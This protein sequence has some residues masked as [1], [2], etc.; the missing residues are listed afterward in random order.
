MFNEPKI[1]FNLTRKWLKESLQLAQVLR[2]DGKI[3]NKLWHE[4]KFV[5]I[6]QRDFPHFGRADYDK[7]EI[8]LSNEC[9]LLE[10]IPVIFAQFTKWGLPEDHLVLLRRFLSRLPQRMIFDIFCQS[11]VD[12]N[13]GH[14][15]HF[16]AGRKSGEIAANDIMIHFASHRGIS[17]PNWKSYSEIISGLL[18]ERVDFKNTKEV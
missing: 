4:I 2:F 8:K 1:S 16:L 6:T 9:L 13:F 14:L 18:Q 11:V 10:E 15:Y 17:D 5:I 12:H 3:L 7:M